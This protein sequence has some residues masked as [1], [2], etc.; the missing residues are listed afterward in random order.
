MDFRVGDKVILLGTK[1]GKKGVQ[2]NKFFTLCGRPKGT[3]ETITAI[4]KG[5]SETHYFVTN[6]SGGSRTGYLI[7]KDIVHQ[8]QCLKDLIQ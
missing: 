1:N 5:Y 8:S 3:V 4:F 6:S 2:F 7:A